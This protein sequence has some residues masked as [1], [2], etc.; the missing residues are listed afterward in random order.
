[1]RLWRRIPLGLIVVA[2]TL[3]VMAAAWWSRGD[4]LF[5]PGPLH[6]APRRA[7]PL[8][9]VHSH[10]E[11]ANR[12]AACHP[13]PFSGQHMATL[14]LAC[15]RDVQQQIDARRP[16]HGRLTQVQECRACHT[17]HA[18]PQAAITDLAHFDHSVTAFALTGRHLTTRCALC[19]QDQV[20]KG[21]P[22]TCVACHAEPRVHLG[23]FG[24]DCARCHS[25]ATW[26]EPTMSLEFHKFPIRHGG[27][28]NRGACA[29]CHTQAPDYHSYTCYCCHRH[30]P[31]KTAE[32]HLKWNI[33]ELHTCAKCHPTGRKRP[34]QP[35]KQKDVA[36]SP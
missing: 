34:D 4:A 24:T 23:R 2:A 19:H 16:L 18:G 3:A 28:K 32:K 29:T 9:G 21:T 22:R 10:A 17:E 33:V 1:M 12:C 36:A 30:D 14:C 8:G 15:H 27:G 35:P 6:A 25:T 26:K 5:S 13:R 31:D 7:T 11:L 20:Y